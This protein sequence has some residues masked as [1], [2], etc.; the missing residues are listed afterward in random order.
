M[1]KIIEAM[2]Q[3]A[4]ISF[5]IGF[6]SGALYGYQKSAEKIYK[7]K[8]NDLHE[9]TN[10]NLLTMNMLKYGCQGG[11]ILTFLPITLPLYKYIYSSK[12]NEY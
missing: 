9:I 7:Q 11:L 12:K 4:L 3:Y 1:D 6:V 5:E 2:K 8:Y 10:I